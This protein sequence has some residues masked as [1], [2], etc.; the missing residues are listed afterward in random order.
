MNSGLSTWSVR[1]PIGVV[2]M[3]LAVIVLGGFALNQLNVDLLPQITYPDVRVRVLD[4]GVPATVMEDE[5]TRQ[6]EEQLAITEGVIAIQSRTSEGR[7]AI[8]L[9]FRY[10]DDVDQALRDASARLDRAK[11]FLPD[12]IDPPI[13]SKRDPFQLPVAEYVVGSTLR[14]PIE[15]RD[16]VDYDLG[17]QLLTLPGV[18]PVELGG[19]LER[20]DSII[21]DQYRLAGLGLDVLDLQARLQTANQDVPAGRLLMR[22]GEISARTGGRFD[23]VEQIAALPLGDAANRGA[24][25]LRLGEVAQV[26][27]SG[28]EER[29]RIR[30]DD[31]PGIK[32]SIQKQPLSNTVAVVNAVDAELARLEAAGLVPDDIQI[33]KVDDQARYIRQS[34]NNAIQ[35][36]LG[37]ALLAMLVVYLFLGS[38]RRTLIIGSAIPIAILVTF[39]L[40]A[41]FGL[42]FNIMTLGGLA[43][44]IGMLVD[45]TI[46]M[47]ENIHRHQRRGEPPLTAASNAAREVSGAIIAST[48]TNLAA[49]LPF[50]F[51]GGLIG[52]L[53]RELIFTISAAIVASL[54]VALTLV[55]AL[56]RQLPAG[57]D[58]PLRRAVDRAM[59]AP[60]NGYRWI[61]RR[62]LPRPWLL[63]P[64]F[65]VAL[66]ASVPSLFSATPAFLPE[67]DEGDV[68]IS[69]TADSGVNLEQM[70]ALTRQVEAT[71]DAQPETRSIFTT[72]GGFV[73]GRS[74]F[75]NSHRASLQVQLVP[76]AERD[77]GTAEWIERVKAEIKAAAIPGLRVYLYTRGIR[78][79][80]FNR[81]D[82]DLSLRLKGPELDTL[83]ALAD[84]MLERL[85]GIE[86]LRNLQHSNQEPTRELSIEVDRQRAA[87]HG[88]DVEDIGR[89]LR[90]ALEGQVITELIE[91]DRSI[92]VRLRLDRDDIAAPGDLESIIL[93]GREPGN[94][95]STA[96]DAR[97]DARL[98]SERRPIRLGDLAQVS[99]LLQPETI[100]RDRQQRIVEISASIGGDLT[101]ASAIEQALAAPPEV[102]LPPGYSLYEAGS[103]E[104]LQQGQD[105][106]RLLLA[107]AVFLV[108]VVMAVQYESVRN[109]FIILLSVPFALIGVALGLSWTDTGLSMP[110]WLGM[111]MLAGIVVNNA[112]VLVEFI[113]LR[114]RAGDSRDEG[115]IEAARLRLR[116]ILMTTLTT[117]FG[118][119]PLALGIGEGSEML[120][121]LA[122]TIVAGL[123]FST[124]VSLLLVPSIYRL[125]GA[126][127]VRTPAE[128][129]SPTAARAV[130]ALRL[131]S[132]AI[133]DQKGKP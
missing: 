84:Q 49:V 109:P 87:S 20:E 65:I 122:I 62:L 40:M 96:V 116:P 64:V 121:P 54:V 26:L 17:R 89:V 107:L 16:L 47:L 106:G 73:F 25:Q 103:L 120:S 12:S 75:E 76:L 97:D 10:G 6:L 91:G 32:L 111:I 57:R 90:L 14:D 113:E 131:D 74:S 35:A 48:S 56:A 98:R 38:L 92:D 28:A 78:G 99:V 124:L 123:S 67:L 2:M 34:L 11:R 61:L 83:I 115:I 43:L 80:R 52:L 15:L 36:A 44:G 31:A 95:V 59:R 46:V 117:V 70:D 55:P 114:R 82:D 13:I 133:R 1:H 112:I 128:A 21:A 77:L 41:A 39:I 58:G 60:E 24:E 29:L 126:R 88:L 118:M 27:D 22:D 119:L 45:S 110:V 100:M 53:F 86:G 130:N 85:Q 8:D 68:R 125:L 3:T 81:G 129:A 18:A 101:L 63:L 4:P 127:T 30:L 93:F 69:L 19:G 50:L 23:S 79:I 7:S 132:A 33:A 71:V 51:I 72:V 9:S 105:I 104:T 94:R 66:I 102:P 5:I 108:L 42:T 37:G